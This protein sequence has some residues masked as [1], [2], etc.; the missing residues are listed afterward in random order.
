MRKLCIIISF[1]LELITMTAHSQS[2][3]LKIDS[4]KKVLITQKEDTNKINILNQLARQ[5][6]NVE[7]EDE[8]N[9][10]R[11]YA[12]Q[13]LELATRVGFLRGKATA[14]Q[15]LGFLLELE[16]RFD[17]ARENYNEVLSI[18]KKLEDKKGEA[19]IYG[20]FASSYNG[21]GN[22]PEAI[23][24][25]YKA[26][27][28]YEELGDNENVPITYIG[29]ATHYI[30]QK[31]YEKAARLLDDALPAIN[32]LGYKEGIAI[33]QSMYAEI[34]YAKGNF[35]SSL[36][37]DSIAIALYLQA[38]SLFNQGGVF[39]NMA[40]NYERIG[41]ITKNK[42]DAAANYRMAL[43]KLNAAT[44][45]YKITKTSQ[46]LFKG[47]TKMGSLYIKLRDL[48]S[49]RYYLNKSFGYH[50][51]LNNQVKKIYNEN[52]LELYLAL[53]KLDSA[54]GNL[55]GAYMNYKQYSFYK[56]SIESREKIKQQQQLFMQYEFDKKEAASKSEQEK[57]DIQAKRIRYIQYGAIAAVL[58]LAIFFY[59]I[60]R[61]RKKS[62]IE[63]E[64][65]YSRLK[66][67]QQQLIQNE[68][69]AS[70]GELTSG[71][72]HEIQNP[73]NFVNNFSEVNTELIEE[74]KEELKAGKTDDAIRLADNIRSNNDKIAF[75]GKRAD[76]IVKGML[77]HSRSGSGQKEATDI[78][79]L[80]DECLRLSYHGM[81]AKDKS[82]NAKTDTSFDD[83]L[84]KVNI[85]SQDIGRVL[86]N[87]FTNSF[88]SVIQ[89]KKQV[90]EGYT[91]VVSVS[92]AKMGNMVK[93]V[94]KDNGNGIPQKVIDKIFQ[95]FFTTKP[96]GEGTGLGLS[97]SYDIITKGH[98]GELKADSRE[99]EFAAFT[100][101]LPV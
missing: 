59:L 4:L 78:N 49:A 6:M 53:S 61:Q 58:V 45:V 73:L 92:T 7:K 37:R 80:A 26:L 82:F 21:E 39:F 97:M 15:L 12:S 54:S 34:D 85:I 16:D 42:N 56:D 100:I 67:T 41:D 89:K 13:A 94:V 40:D 68:K 43:N 96:T 65:A 9:Q 76:S 75:H 44:A 47:F 79:N 20:S 48:D 3:S 17:E 8:R 64:K 23:A 2:D 50:S 14:L 95:P 63:I 30:E 55:A 25:E 69:M 28:I 91:S 18:C 51:S 66:E 74:M 10:C 38:N 1:F 70:L 101:L 31:D 29:L 60:S 32:K 86:L 11:Q 81:R 5:L 90:G 27:K 98:N 22:A 24:N 88:Y 52:L 71:I 33:V 46:F 99:G 72:A 19:D 84:P 93:I 36:R 35:I 57:K 77:Q 62:K 83:S 87:L